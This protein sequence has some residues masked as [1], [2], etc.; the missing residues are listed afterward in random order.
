MPPS[1]AYLTKSR[2]KL[3]LECPTKL[4]YT[5]HQGQYR[6]RNA[7]NEFL[8]GLAEGGHQVGE[9]AKFRYHP[10][11]LGARITI[12]ALDPDEAVAETQTRLER[13]GR[14]VIA[15]AA[16][17]ADRFLIRVDVM[18]VD[19]DA[20][21]V[22]LIEVKSKS[23]SHALAERGFKNTSGTIKPE[24]LPYLYD[25]AFQHEVA[26]RALPG[27]TIK[28]RLLLLDAE[29]A[30][31]TTGLHQCF[32]VLPTPD[33][34]GRTRFRVV[35][36]EALR[37]EQL[38]SMAVLTEVDVSTVVAE[39]R[40]QPVPNTAHIPAEFATNLQT[41][42][43]WAAGI[44][45]DGQRAF[46]GV[47]KQC[48]TCEFRASSDDPLESGVHECW[49]LAIERGLLH[50]SRNAS[51][52]SAPLAIDLWS[53][54]SGNSSPVDQLI[55]RGRAFLADVEEGDLPTPTTTANRP[56]LTPHQRRL[57]QIRATKD[58]PPVVVNDDV[59]AEMDHWQWP[60]HLI[61]FE[62]SAPAI[63]FFAGMRPYETIAFQFSHHTLTKSGDGTV[64]ITHANQWISTEANAYPNVDFVRA[65]KAA[66]A[67]N[68]SI[69]GTVFR[70]HN[71]E[72]SV[73]RSLRRE[74]ACSGGDVP[75][76][77]D[78]IRFIDDI[79]SPTRADRELGYRTEGRNAMVDLHALVERGY[80]SAR[81]GGS[82][83]LKHVLPAI[84][85]DAPGL[86]RTFQQPG[87]YGVGLP[88]ASLNFTDPH[89]HVW[90]PEGPAGDP[91]KTLPPVT[92]AL[93]EDVDAM[94]ERF[95]STNGDEGDAIDQGGIAMLAYNL[96]H[97]ADLT[98][99]GREA[100][101]DALLCYCE[102]DTLAMA[103]LILGLMELRG[104]PLTVRC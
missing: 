79:T 24:W 102:L 65:L 76:G 101:R 80:Y 34:N 62:T 28:P 37:H 32:K 16:L 46:H 21:S 50:G 93:G 56:G 20:R 45:A 33:A 87:L 84:L 89:G 48:R 23:V 69:E 71:H 38:G 30:A 51:D 95:A 82:V 60:L 83:S 58:G 54:K 78:L 41:F 14:H 35:T 49:Q 19:H 53:G 88:L 8:R 90:L 68:G 73:L 59:L 31:D 92:T 86:A 85:A 13:P 104:R 26:C 18:I 91:Y 55:A 12:D 6:N 97:F 98:D 27:F 3:A 70:Y 103:M 96:T 40:E 57:A 44:W 2:F 36:D 42:M 29:T 43:E 10:D 94:L 61:D 72:N 1:S 11:P 52:R 39:L 99:A 77:V 81:S 5:R 7:D 9:L 25:V 15:E 67:P 22:E 66:L 4:F 64:T 47:S 17:R 100:I 75:D 63:P 74:I